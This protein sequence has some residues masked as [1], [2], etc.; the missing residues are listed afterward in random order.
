MKKSIRIAKLEL[1]TLFYSPIAWLLL[2]A[3]FVQCA[4]A[5]IEKLQTWVTLQELGGH[6]KEQLTFLTSAIFGYPSGIAATVS[7]Y[8]YLYLPLLTMGLISREVNNGTIKLLYSSPVTTIKIVIGKFLAICSYALLLVLAFG[9]FLITGAIQ[10]QHPDIGLLLSI[11]LGIFLLLAAYGAIGLFVSSLTSYQVVAAVSTFI[12]FA[13]LG[14]I[15]SVWQRIDFVRDITYSLSLPG[16]VGNMG[17]GFITTKDLFYFAV[18]LFLFISLTIMKLQSGRSNDSRLKKLLKYISLII[19]SIVISYVTSRP[20][21]MLYFDATATKTHTLSTASQKILKSMTAGPLEIT[22]YINLLES[23]YPFGD[24]AQRN[25]DIERW[26]PYIRFKPDIH[27]NYVYYYDSVLNEPSFFKEYPGKSLSEIAATFAKSRRIDLDVFKKPEEIR[28]II[29]LRTEQNRYVMQLKYNGKSTFLRLFDDGLVFPTERE[30]DAALKRMLVRL[31]RVAFLDGE[32][33]RSPYRLGD[34]DY[35]GMTSDITFR[36]AMI[37][38]GFDFTTITLKNDTIPNNISI[39]VIADPKAAFDSTVLTKIKKF[40]DRGGNLL[41]ACEPGKQT[42]LN[43]LLKYVGVS[44]DSGMIVQKSDD[45]SPDL[46]LA[47]LTGA[48]ASLSKTLQKI[49]H[50]SLL[51]SMPTVT[52]LFYKDT[53]N[54]RV[55]PFL[56][57]DEKLAWKKMGSLSADSLTVNFNS[58]DGDERGKFI[59]MLGLTRKIT[60]CCEQ[61]IIVSADADFMTT[62]EL[63]RSNMVGASNF[64]FCTSL[65]GWLSNGEFPVDITRPDSPD[66]IILLKGDDIPLLKLIFVWILPFI[67]FISG[68]VLLVR[69]NRQ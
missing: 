63:L 9:V 4:M 43:P 39:L 51:I 68:T 37:N 44:M 8:I 49:Y 34:K 25:D 16:H 52:G 6:Y 17:T 11:M 61:R 40:I 20:A 24:P 45:F 15:G 27:L 47:H 50:D 53:N 26:V 23:H 46:V 54:F 62:L 32:L 29:T 14:F 69:R 38:Q 1:N 31:P 3:F 65:F 59:T 58:A 41:I 7:S 57:T 60:S 66:N 10:L 12:V 67:I 30:T 56:M 33:E 13:F 55:Q 28:K 36:Y 5:Y 64:S 42:V 48:L 19:F 35:R 22:S 2:I 18:I 21:F